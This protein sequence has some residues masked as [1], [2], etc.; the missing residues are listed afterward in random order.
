MSGHVRTT[1]SASSARPA[2]CQVPP[3]VGPGGTADVSTVERI[4]EDL[5]QE[6]RLGRALLVGDAGARE[7]GG[8]GGELA[9]HRAGAAF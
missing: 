3:C 8:G 6:Y 1:A 5:R 7:G 9:S 2:R 4:K